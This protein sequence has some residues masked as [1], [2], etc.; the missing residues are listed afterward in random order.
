MVFPAPQDFY[1]G[2]PAQVSRRNGQRSSG[3]SL[4]IARGSVEAPRE[5]I[6]AQSTPDKGTTFHFI[7]L[8]AA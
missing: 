6:W 7:I 5:E 4:A 2:D 1:T 3:T 8:E